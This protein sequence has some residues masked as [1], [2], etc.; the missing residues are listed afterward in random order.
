MVVV[1]TRGRG[2]SCRET[3]DGSTCVHVVAAVNARE[4]EGWGSRQ[5]DRCGRRQRERG[6]RGGYAGVSAMWSSSMREREVWGIAMREKSEGG[7][8]M[9]CCRQRTSLEWWLPAD[10][11]EMISKCQNTTKP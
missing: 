11:M 8:C 5:A 1:D 4:V 6:W 3:S 7:A 9:L 10:A 2:G